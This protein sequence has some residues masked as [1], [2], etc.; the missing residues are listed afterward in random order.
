MSPLTIYYFPEITCHRQYFENADISG[1]PKH[2]YKY[3]DQV[4]YVCKNGFTGNFSITCKKI[5][6]T[7]SRECTGKKI[8]ETVKRTNT[9]FPSF[10]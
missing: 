4:E 8:H 2:T 1:T 10:L 9:V 6:W 7:G 3:N 5:G